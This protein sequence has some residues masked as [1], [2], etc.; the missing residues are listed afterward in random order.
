MTELCDGTLHDLVVVKK[1]SS[2][3]LSSHQLRDVVLCQIVEGLKHLHGYNILHRDL[4]PRNILY[5]LIDSDKGSK[6]QLVMKLADFGCSRSLPKD[7]THHTRSEKSNGDFRLF[8]TDGWIAPEVLNGVKELKPP[9]AVDIYPLGLI[10]PYTLC[11]GR[12]PFGEDKTAEDKTARD[13]RI[14]N[15]Q[16]MLE[17]IRQQLIDGYGIKCLDLVNRMLDPNPEGRPTTSQLLENENF[18]VAIARD[19]KVSYLL[20]YFFFIIYLYHIYIYS[21]I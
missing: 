11:G 19:R 6:K 7:A 16:P 5:R 10:F 4:K 17:D 12:H 1:D 14:K 3:K 9:H 2:I 20:T 18:F 15:K 8:G 21:R 13:T